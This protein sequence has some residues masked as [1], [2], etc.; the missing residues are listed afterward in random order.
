MPVM[1]AHKFRA[2]QQVEVTGGDV[3]NL[4]QRDSGAAR[5]AEK[6]GKVFCNWRK[7]RGCGRERHAE[8]SR[9]VDGE[10]GVTERYVRGRDMRVVVRLWL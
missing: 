1:L 9:D 7:I 6:S 3:L 5:R 8:D 2:Q 10:D 4:A